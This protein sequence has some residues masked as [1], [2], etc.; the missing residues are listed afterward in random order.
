VA[1]LEEE[2]R[3]AQGLDKLEKQAIA[4]RDK[5]MAAA[6]SLR[7]EIDALEAILPSDLWPVPTYSELLFRL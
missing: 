3:K 1:K 2:T 4:Y 7:A 6:V 5:V